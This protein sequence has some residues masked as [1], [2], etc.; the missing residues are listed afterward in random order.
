MHASY[1]HGYRVTKLAWRSRK[2]L[3]IFVKEHI[4]NF[5]RKAIIRWLQHNHLGSWGY[6]ELYKITDEYD[7]F[8]FHFQLHWWWYYFQ[9]HRWYSWCREGMNR[10]MLGLCRQKQQNPRQE[11][12]VD[13]LVS[14]NLPCWSLVGCLDFLERGPYKRGQ[15]PGLP[16]PLDPARQPTQSKTSAR[17]YAM[18]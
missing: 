7:S 9:L 1:N 5:Y 18:L 2:L 15:S 11:M 10:I 12:E 3:V 8:R 4:P 13:W 14:R 17:T 16:R 6:R